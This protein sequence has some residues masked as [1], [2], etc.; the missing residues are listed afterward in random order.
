MLRRRLG[1]EWN[2]F[3]MPPPP[4]SERTMDALYMH[5]LFGLAMGCILQ[6]MKHKYFGFEPATV[7]FSFACGWP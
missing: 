5:T 2:M 3:C 7:C 4:L 6:V 1:K